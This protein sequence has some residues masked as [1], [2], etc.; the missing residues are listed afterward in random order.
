MAILHQRIQLHNSSG[1]R[2][3]VFMEIIPTILTNDPNELREKIEIL[4]RGNRQLIRRVQ[5]DIV[6]GE[7]ANNKTVSVEALASIN[8]DLLI[9]VQLMVPE[10]VSWVEKCVEVMAD[11]IIGH[12]EQ[13][14]D[15]NEFIARVGSEGVGVGLGLD[16]HTPVKAIG[17]VLSD[18]DVVLLMSVEVG[19]GGQEFD[20]RV[21]MKV[22]ELNQIRK[23]KNLRFNICVD[24][25]IN[26]G[27]M[28]ALLEAGADE[29]AV[30]KSLW[31]EGEVGENIEKLMRLVE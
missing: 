28:L 6:E 29:V 11:R 1:E 4:T 26:E 9:D 5:V 2:F 24:G 14:S 20:E 16:I 21:L 7:F 3:R 18:L 22:A 23:D 19:F 25:G 13:M 17:E 10:P 8:T 27:N 12:V 15:Q 31:K 30:G